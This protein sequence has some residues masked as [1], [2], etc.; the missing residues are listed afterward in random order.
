MIFALRGRARSKS[1]VYGGS[2]AHNAWPVLAAGRRMVLQKVVDRRGDFLLVIYIND[3][4]FR[5][6]FRPHAARYIQLH[7][8]AR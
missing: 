6:P 4:R 1:G 5:S 7:K 2:S 8:H 3:E